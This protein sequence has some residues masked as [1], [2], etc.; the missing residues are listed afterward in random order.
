[1]PATDFL[2]EAGFHG[3]RRGS[4]T[5]AMNKLRLVPCGVDAVVLDT[6]LD[7]LWA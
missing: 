7:K 4:A 1:M 3:R 5:E 6:G 2:E